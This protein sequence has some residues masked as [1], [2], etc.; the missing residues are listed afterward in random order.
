[1]PSALYAAD[2][3]LNRG[4]GVTKQIDRSSTWL[5]GLWMC[6]VQKHCGDDIADGKGNKN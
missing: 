1:M 5:C 4:D 6:R 3:G 2:P